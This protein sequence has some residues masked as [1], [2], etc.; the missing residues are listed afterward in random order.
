MRGPAAHVF[1]FVLPFALSLCAPAITQAQG[2]PPAPAVTVSPALAQKI[3]EWDEYTGRFE[4]A[5]FVEVRARVSGFVD[6]VNF[7][8]GQFV[9]KGDL[10]Y[11]LD[12]RPFQIEIEAA[13]AEIAKANS[14][15]AFN[16]S[17]VARVEPLIKTGAVTARDADQRRANLLQAQAQVQASTAALKN[18]Q[19]NF[20]WAEVRAAAAGRISNTKVNAGNLVAGGTNGATLLTT[21]VSISPIRFG[22]DASEADYLRYSRQ[23]KSGDRASSRDISN[24]VRVRIGDETSWDR[25]GKMDFV[26]NQINPRSG[27]IR[28]RAVFDNTDGFLT[29]GTFGR[30]RL[31]GGETD[32]LLVPD[33]AIVADQ[34]RKVVMTLGPDDKVVPKP[35]VLGPL[36]NGLRV[37][38]SGL[39]P[40]DDVIF[41]GLANP[42]VRPGVKVTPTKGEIKAI[43]SA[44]Q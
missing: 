35:V 18:A 5:E 29:P 23:S 32:A 21:I 9:K 22:F 36:V 34:A 44:Q 6:S 14:A 7:T 33:A 24:P 31:Y 37:I 10:L 20:E 30:L 42:F 16:Q 12:K 27:T 1:R 39:A 40:S 19:L 41:G 38:R 11:T 13:K 17:E 25:A 26:D 28:G 43:V 4:A 8:D 15:V 3:T 2:A